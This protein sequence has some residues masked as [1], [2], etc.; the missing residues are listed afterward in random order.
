MIFVQLATNITA[1]QTAIH[2]VTGI[3]CT[4]ERN[5]I[6]CTAHWALAT[7]TIA[8]QDAFFFVTVVELLA[9]TGAQM[10]SC[11]EGQAAVA[12]EM[13]LRESRHAQEDVGIH[14]VADDLGQLVPV[15]VGQ[16]NNFHRHV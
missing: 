1:T 6:G 10:F 12:L 4:T 2:H 9:H 7:F 3:S 13:L 16:T 15:A 8:R 5:A 11:C 14:Q